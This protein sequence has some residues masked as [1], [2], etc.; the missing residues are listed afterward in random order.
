M[1]TWRSTLALRAVALAML[2]A[3]CVLPA[4]AAT[5][6]TD[7]RITIAE[8]TWL[9]AATM[10]HLADRILST[11]YGCNTELV[12]GDTVPTASSL[13]AKGE[14]MIMPELWMGSLGEIWAK[15]RAKGIAFK[16]GDAFTD[17]GN[18]GWFIPD[19]VAKANPG[20]KSVADLP[21]YAHL[22]VEP[23]SG[24]KARLYGCPPGWACEITNANLFKAAGLADKGFELFSPG[25]GANL[26]ASIARKVARRQPVLAYYWGPT[27]VIGKYH[28]VKLDMGPFDQQRFDCIASS[29]C[30]EPRLTDFRKG[31]IAVVA[32]TSLERDAPAVV[33]FL[34]KMRIPNET[35]QSV[36]AWGDDA[37]A[38]PREIATHF[39]K[40]QAPLW[41]TWVPQDVA[42]KVR[43]SLK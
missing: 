3:P 43:E 24:A 16:A 28:L 22:F 20:L 32:V 17:G 15:V 9:S 21:D 42:A 29:D 13:L 25:S 11:G 33:A 7:A 40:T 35:I 19:Y 41:T 38:S 27:E 31:E 30:R 34:S 5:C 4:K 14:P 18:E 2:A 23:A 6:G 36:L 39:L 8:M 12:P 37:S 10:A 1:K 26:K